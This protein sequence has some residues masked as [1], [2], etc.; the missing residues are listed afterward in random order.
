[1]IELGQKTMCNALILHLRR[2]TAVSNGLSKT[3]LDFERQTV[4]CEDHLS[5][6]CAADLRDE[7]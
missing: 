6:E 2:A 3:A 7:V 1:V 5:I 4:F